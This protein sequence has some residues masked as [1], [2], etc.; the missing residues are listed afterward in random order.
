[1]VGVPSKFGVSGLRETDRMSQ[2][3]LGVLACQCLR[4]LVPRGGER[5]HKTRS[6]EHSSVT[7][8]AHFFAYRTFQASSSGINSRPRFAAQPGG[9]IVREKKKR[10]RAQCSWHT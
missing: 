6:L 4:G 2:T 1:M 9:E 5:R 10:A 7:T 8:H 3:R